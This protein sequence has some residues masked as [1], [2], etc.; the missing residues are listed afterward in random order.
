MREISMER[1]EQIRQERYGRWQWNY[2]YSP[3]YSLRKERR[4]EGVG[5]I[6]VSMDVKDG[7]LEQMEFYGDYFGSE[8][9]AELAQVLQGCAME[10]SA[11]MER[12]SRI[13]VDRYFHR[14]TAE[15]LVD[16]LLQ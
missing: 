13:D 9:G 12:L 6:L 15:Q 10:R 8:D 16:I 14:L 5:K 7:K 3:Q 2:G 4:I 11:L 1:V